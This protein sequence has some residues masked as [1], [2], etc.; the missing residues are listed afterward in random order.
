MD[1]TTA[2]NQFF[3]FLK[4]NYHKR[5]LAAADILLYNIEEIA[6]YENK[7]PF[8]ITELEAL[9]GA[10]SWMEY[11]YDGRA[12]YANEDLRITYFLDAYD[13]N[14]YL[15]IQGDLLWKAWQEWALFKYY[16]NL[17]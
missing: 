6:E 12:L 4:R 5:V 11:S 17:D 13:I 7:S 2:K 8:E 1:Y 9:N 3:E 15:E 10:N 14:Q 16:R